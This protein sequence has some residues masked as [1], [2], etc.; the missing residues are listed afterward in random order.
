[1]PAWPV[2]QRDRYAQARHAAELLQRARSAL[3]GAGGPLHW[4]IKQLWGLAE[5]SSTA[6]ALTALH[7]TSLWLQHPQVALLYQGAWLR[8][9][10]YSCA[11]AACVGHQP[12]LQ[13]PVLGTYTASSVHQRELWSSAMCQ[14]VGRRLHMI[15]ACY[16]CVSPRI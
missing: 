7:L 11:E 4:A 16:L 6:A 15:L 1:M 10:L 13:V 8:L 14:W 12:G 3:H 5:R 9:L 2:W